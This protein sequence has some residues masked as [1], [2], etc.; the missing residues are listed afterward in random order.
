MVK[1][2]QNTFH[3]TSP[4]TRYIGTH[5]R[6]LKPCKEAALEVQMSVHL[7]FSPKVWNTITPDRLAAS[8]A[9]KHQFMLQ[10]FRHIVKLHIEDNL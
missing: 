10:Q 6:R 2:T 1:L 9:T 3:N 4:V 5:Y 7:T 8:H